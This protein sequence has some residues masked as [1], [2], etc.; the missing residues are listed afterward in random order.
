MEKVQ[1]ANQAIS[2]FAHQ[3]EC[4]TRGDPIDVYI[5]LLKQRK[6]ER[7]TLVRELQILPPCTDPDCPDHSS[8]A[9]AESGEINL[10]KIS[11]TVE[12]KKRQNNRKKIKPKTQR[13]QG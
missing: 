8:P 3:I 9:Q 10:V 13:L 6:Q 11:Q 1:A 5:Q 2:F 4:P 12:F 7:E